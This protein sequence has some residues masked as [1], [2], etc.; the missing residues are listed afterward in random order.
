MKS[1]FFWTLVLGG[2]AYVAY[3]MAPDLRRELKIATM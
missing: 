2:F 3:R 1:K